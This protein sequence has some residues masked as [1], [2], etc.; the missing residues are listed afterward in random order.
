MTNFNFSANR[1]HAETQFNLGKGEYFK[2]KESDNRVR[3]VSPYLAHPC[4]FNG[5]PNFKWLCQVLD[6]TDEKVKSYFLPDRVYHYIMDLQ[7]DPDYAF[8]EVLMP[9]NNNIITENAGEIT[10][11]YSV[12]PSPK[13]IPLTSEE[14]KAIEAAPNVLD[15]QLKSVKARV[16]PRS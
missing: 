13:R 1:E 8:E 10:V 2:P 11:K 14:L 12:L 9:Y 15:L 4:E 5:K 6:I 3:L 16:M 7:L